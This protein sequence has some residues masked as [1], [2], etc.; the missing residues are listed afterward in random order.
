MLARTIALFLVLAGGAAAQ[1]LRIGMKAAIDGSDPHQSYSPN[2]NVQLHVYEPLVFQDAYQ[3]PIP[4]LAESW[5]LIDATTWEFRLREGVTF[6]NGTPLHASDVIFSIQRAREARG[7]RTYSQNVRAITTMEAPDARTVILRTG[8]PAPMLP[9]LLA[10]VGIVSAAAVGEAASEAD[11]NGGRAAIGTGPFRWVRYTP[12]ADVVIERAERHWAPLEPWRRVTYRFIPNDSARV[13]ALLADDVDVIDAVPPALQPRVREDARTRLVVATTSFN[14]YIFLDVYR[15]VAPFVTTTDGQPLNRNP[16]R[17][18]RVRRALSHA[19]NRQA[20]ATRAMEGGAEPAGQVTPPNFI[21]HDPDL[22]LPAY[23]P[24][25]ARR[26][27]AEAGYPGGFGL[28]LQCTADRFA[29]DARTCQAIGQMFTAVGLRTI[30]ETLPTSVF[31]R[32]A[33][34]G[35]A[36]NEPEFS[37]SMSIFASTSG[38]ASESMN[39][40]LRTPNATLGHGASNRG[41]NADPVLDGLLERIESELDDTQRA[42]LTRAATRRVMEELPVIPVFWVR[43]AWGVRSNI[44]LA[45]RGDAYT[46][47]TSIRTATVP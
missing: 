3:R 33:G 21:G 19:I 30:V 9:S 6:H 44:R 39:T 1:E 24:G 18:V 40:I 14:F 36:Q 17:D 27:L 29:G 12:G 22:G 43:S 23:D 46:M 11:W 45:P 7:I 13:A 15:D 35:Y 10:S 38:L 20:L 31:F 25:L 42:A 16:Y 8:G 26:L 32:R 41:R 2:R 5:R 47:A 4:G 37:A 34:T 28:T